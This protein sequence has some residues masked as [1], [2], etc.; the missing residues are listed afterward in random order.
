MSLGSRVS[1]LRASLKP[2]DMK[3]KHGGGA[4]SGPLGLD[5]YTMEHIRV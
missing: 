3:G 4:L 2:Q 5:S 1:G